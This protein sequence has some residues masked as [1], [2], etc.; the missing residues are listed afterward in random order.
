MEVVQRVGAGVRAAGAPDPAPGSAPSLGIE[1]V[2]QRM[3]VALG[4]VD[5]EP[6]ASEADIGV[7]QLPQGL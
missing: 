7:A 4:I 6:G 2:G 5:H 3:R 1:K